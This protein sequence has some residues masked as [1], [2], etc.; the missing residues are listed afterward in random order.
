MTHARSAR[1]RRLDGDGLAQRRSNHHHHPACGHRAPPG[2]H[3]VFVGRPFLFAAAAFGADGVDHGIRLLSDE[4][5]RDMVMLGAR[6]LG[7][8]GPHMLRD[9]LGAERTRRGCQG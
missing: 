5:D 7:D 4:I 3:F 6:Q 8:L 1:W 2:S 9:R